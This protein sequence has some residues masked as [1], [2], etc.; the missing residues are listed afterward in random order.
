MEENYEE[1]SFDEF[2]LF[3]LMHA[4]ASD[5]DVSIEEE[6]H[7]IAKYSKEKYEEVK[8]FYQ[9]QTDFDKML[10]I[11]HFKDEVLKTESEKEKVYKIIEELFHAD[12]EYSADEKN[13]MITLRTI[14]D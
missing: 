3:L 9:F 2:V 13:L 10:I 7:I 8:G 5:L 12:G 11:H 4:A 14:L 1:W 6:N